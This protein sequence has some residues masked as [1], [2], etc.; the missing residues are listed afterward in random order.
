MK[1]GDLVRHKILKESRTV[2]VIT[3]KKPSNEY[4]W[5]VYKVYWTCMQNEEYWLSGYEIEVICK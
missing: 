3:Q 5:D 1:V 2:G 4:R